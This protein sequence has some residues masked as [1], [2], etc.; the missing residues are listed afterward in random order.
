MKRQNIFQ[1]FLNTL[2][3]NTCAGDCLPIVSLFLKFEFASN[4]DYFHPANTALLS[5]VDIVAYKWLPCVGIDAILLLLFF[6]TLTIDA[7]MGHHHRDK[8]RDR[9]REDSHRHHHKKK[10][11]HRESSEERHRHR[12]KE[13]NDKQREP[14][15]DGEAV[16]GAIAQWD[17]KIMGYTNDDNPFGDSN[18]G[19]TFVWRKKL[20]KCGVKDIDEKEIDALNKQRMLK[21]RQELEKVKQSRL[22]RER[23]REEHQEEMSRIQR[24]K[25]ADQFREFAQ[26]EDY[27]HLKQAKLRSKLRIKDNRAKPIDLLAQYIGVFGDD[28]LCMLEDFQEDAEA[29]GDEEKQKRF[30]ARRDEEEEELE[31]RIRLLSGRLDQPYNNL[32]GLRIRDLEDLIEDIHVYMEHDSDTK[33]NANYWQDLLV[34]SEDELGKL[35]LANLDDNDRRREGINPSVSTEIANIL[36]DKT[37]EQL[38]KLRTQVEKKIRSQEEGIDIGYWETLLSRLK[39]QISRARLR[40]FH[41][42][43]MKGKQELVRKL[44]ERLTIIKPEAAALDEK[45]SDYDQDVAGPSTSAATAYSGGDK[46]MAHFLSQAEIERKC[47]QEYEEGRYSPTPV[48]I[49]NIPTGTLILEP[50]DYQRDLREQRTTTLKKMLAFPTPF[51]K[52]GQEDPVKKTKPK[53]YDRNRKALSR[54]EEAFVREAK[55]GMGE[56]EAIFSVE[57]ELLEEGEMAKRKQ[58]LMRTGGVAAVTQSGLGSWLVKAEQ[59]WAEKYQPRKPRYFNRVHTGFEW[60]KYNQTHYDMDN[61]PPKVVQGYKFNIF[62]PDLIDKSVTPTYKITP[63]SENKDFAFI[64]FTAGPPYEDICFKIVNREWNY[65]YKSGYKCQFQNNILQLWFHFKRY[66][67]RR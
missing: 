58:E 37:P 55:K 19:Q 56:D 16:A 17:E 28:T 42:K 48:A 12:S 32:N 14:P 8:E 29:D 30:Q 23:E 46:N 47:I 35:K 1:C 39:A 36:K 5:W 34:I 53:S 63:C 44:H 9:S 50:D 41:D 64:R 59:N 26:Q 62:Y 52:V 45:S 24:E 21:N 6:G 31:D 22:E 7:I 10:K 15:I 43:N 40:Q 49:D 25:E 61:P 67:Y 66:R 2:S 18:L 54:T 13:K 57:E 20:E 27:F 65:S 4:F 11:K 38:E 3:I 33:I 51:V 60:N